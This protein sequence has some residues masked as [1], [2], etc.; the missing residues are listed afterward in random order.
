[1]ASGAPIVKVY[2]DKTYHIQRYQGVHKNEYLVSQMMYEMENGPCQLFD[3]GLLKMSWEMKD[4]VRIGYLELFDSGKAVKKTKWEYMFNRQDIRWILNCK[5]KKLMQVCDVQTGKTIYMGNVDKEENRSGFGIEYDENTEKPVRAGIFKSDQLTRLICRFVDENT[6]IEYDNSNSDEI[7]DLLARTPVYVGGYYLDEEQCFVQRHGQGKIIDNLTGVCIRESR[8]ERGV[9]IKESQTQLVNGWYAEKTKSA[10]ANQKQVRASIRLSK[11]EEDWKL[12]EE[13]RVIT[14][15]LRQQLIL[16]CGVETDID[17]LICTQD[18][19]SI[20]IDSNMYNQNYHT[21]FKVSDFP[22][23]TSISIGVKS[24]IHVCRF[25]LSHLPALKEVEIQSYSFCSAEKT[26]TKKEGREL[27]IEGCPALKSFICGDYVF[28]DFYTLSIK[29]VKSL[30]D[31][32]FGKCAFYFAQ[33][34]SLTS[35]N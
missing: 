18:I 10:R 11:L 27:E 16:I 24:F 35:R 31:L 12:Q 6:M 20:D 9:E 2:G 34:C 26:I 19:E 13:E 8:W 21:Q 5:A 29:N 23:L 25:D 15:R 32:K 30:T 1:M 3:D 14:E 17:S 28:D 7:D 22:R 33:T 4:G